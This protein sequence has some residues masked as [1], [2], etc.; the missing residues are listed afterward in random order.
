MEEI[1][2]EV[3]IMI[4]EGQKRTILVYGESP[5]TTVDFM[6]ESIQQVYNTKSE[7]GEIRRT[8]INCAF[9]VQRRT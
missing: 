6:C 8:N 2:E 4:N 3:K 1:S 7:N 9:I 5:E